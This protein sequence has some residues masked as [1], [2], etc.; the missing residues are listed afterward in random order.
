MATQID[1]TRIFTDSTETADTRKKRCKNC[2]VFAVPRGI[3]ET[4]RTGSTGDVNYKQSHCPNC[5]HVHDR[6][7]H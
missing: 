3:T 5:G 4:I 6:A 7:N 2:K 1:A